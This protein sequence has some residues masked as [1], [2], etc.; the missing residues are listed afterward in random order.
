MK[1]RG[2]TKIW[3]RN[4]PCG[5]EIEPLRWALN[6]TESNHEL[7]RW[8]GS[9]WPIATSRDEVT[10]PVP[11]RISTTCKA[12]SVTQPERQAIRFPHPTNPGGTG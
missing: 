4:P 2:I 1:K 10:R 6:L 8:R 5:F 11:T 9:C 7:S 3:L 12:W